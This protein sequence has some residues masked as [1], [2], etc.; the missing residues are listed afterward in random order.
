MGSRHQDADKQFSSDWFNHPIWWKNIHS[1]TCTLTRR[2]P[3]DAAFL[4]QLWETP[5]FIEDFHPLAAPLPASDEKLE[6]ILKQEFADT[7]EKNRNLNWIIRTPDLRPWGLVSLC[8]VSL[9][10]RRA[11]VMLGVLPEKP[12]GLPISAM[13][14]IYLFFFKS[15]KFNK[16]QAFIFPDNTRSLQ[17][18]ANLG[19]RN[20]GLLKKHL[21]YPKKEAFLDVHQMGA[22]EENAFSIKNQKIMKKL[23]A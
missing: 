6:Q 17:T 4:R 8:G 16:L 18:T 12:F 1:R 21:F 15:M 3:E 10:H 2:N 7:L 14:M 13:L 19:F 5:E 9:K 22:L 23:L 20:E 11:E